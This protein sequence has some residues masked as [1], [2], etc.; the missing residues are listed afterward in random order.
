MGDFEGGVWAGGSQAG[1]AG[2]GAFDDEHLPNGNNPSLK[3]PFALGMLKT[4][5]GQYAIRAADLQQTTTLA[6]AFD[7]GSPKPWD[8]QGG[9]VLGVG[10][11]N[12]NVSF[13]TFYEGAITA[14]RPSD[15]T[16][17]AVLKNLR[18]VGYGK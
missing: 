10:S 3:V 1:D 8:N 7:G 18:A 13:G 11:D 2:R 6:T 4:S 12:S 17:A 14:G 15:T 16:D 9:I 5:P